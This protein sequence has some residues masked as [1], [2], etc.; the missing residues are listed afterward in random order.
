MR[1][2]IRNILKYFLYTL[3]WIIFVI[4]IIIVFIL[5]LFFYNQK[6]LIILQNGWEARPWWG[7]FGSIAILEFKWFNPNF[8]IED[9]FKYQI[10]AKEK[11][12]YIPSPRYLEKY[13]IIDRI[14]FLN[15]NVYG[16]PEKDARNIKYLYENI[17]NT[18]INWVILVN[19]LWFEK[20]SNNLRHVIWEWQFL[21]VL[22]LNKSLN[23]KFDTRKAEYLKKSR[24]FIKDNLFSLI[25]VILKNYKF[26]TENNYL[27][28]Y[29]TQY[30]NIL[31]T[32]WL[33]HSYDKDTFYTLDFYFAF[34][35]VSRF[36]DK[37]IIVNNK[38]Y[39]N[40]NYVYLWK[41]F[42][43]EVIVKYSKNKR[44]LQEYKEYF[45]YLEQ[46]Y[47]IRLNYQQRD[48]MWLNWEI[49]HNLSIFYIPNNNFTYPNFCKKFNN[50][51]ICATN[52]SKDIII[53]VR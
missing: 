33:L 17:T 7:F 44:L 14:Y 30:N 27:Q 1:L 20:I 49:D 48:I 21:N 52:I 53:N 3:S 26:L 16:I 45:R 46:K 2:K 29:H 36:L 24:N 32:I 31:K 42:T 47:S 25:Y 12:I 40:K 37:K 35:K 23:S 28:V 43:G 34:R 38:T 41:N 10:L 50:I 6:Y 13:L 4:I 18:K 8:K 39:K 11:N 5:Y 19:S 51:L 22:N 9:A 15:S